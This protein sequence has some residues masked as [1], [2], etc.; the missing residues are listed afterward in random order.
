MNILDFGG[1]GPVPQI[2][3]LHRPTQTRVKRTFGLFRPADG[4]LEDRGRF[5]G[6]VLRSGEGREIGATDLRIEAEPS[7]NRF[8]PLELLEGRVDGTLGVSLI[9]VND[10]Y[11]SK[12]PHH[13]ES[14]TDE[15]TPSSG[16]EGKG[17]NHERPDSQRDELPP[18]R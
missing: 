4:G 16:R 12:G 2:P 10:G 11:L 8:N 7:E 9:F 18:A 17:P 15:A 14:P 13:R 5:R 3:K 6:N 1:L